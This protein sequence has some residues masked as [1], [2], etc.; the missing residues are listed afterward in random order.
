M[1]FYP[2]DILLNVKKLQEGLVVNNLTT[3]ELLFLEDV[4]KM[5]EAISKNC[6]FAAS[7][8]VDP[9]F[10]SLMQTLSSE[11]KHWISTTASIV[12]G[13]KVQ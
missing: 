12:T 10:K 4:T 8:A 3:R 9:Q 11:H 2:W 7:S 1:F 13:K 6:D 5:F